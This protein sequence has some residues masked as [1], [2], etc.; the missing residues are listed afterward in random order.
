MRQ[1]KLSHRSQS[2]AGAA[3]PSLRD[4]LSA[5]FLAAFEADFAAN[6]V[7]AIE[8]LRQKSPEKYAEI[9]ARLMVNNEPKPDDFKQCKSM[10]EIA[11]KLLKSS[12]V[13][14]EDR[15]TPA[16]IQAAIEA[17]NRFVDELKRIA[18]EGLH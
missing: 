4:R 15:I 13:E 10:E 8:Q 1:R 12:G 9:A 3:Q 14:D 11:R 17:N 2:A 6:G 16:M 18:Q 5:N 7:A